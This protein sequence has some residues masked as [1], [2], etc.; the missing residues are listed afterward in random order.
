MMYTPIKYTEEDNGLY[1]YRRNGTSF[2]RRFAEYCVLGLE[3]EL[4]ELPKTLLSDL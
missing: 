2:V 1:N 4:N 3:L